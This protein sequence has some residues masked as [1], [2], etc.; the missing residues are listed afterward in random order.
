MRDGSQACG[1]RL[2]VLKPV[3]LAQLALMW[4][5][6]RRLMAPSWE[7][8]VDVDPCEAAAVSLAGECPA[9]SSSEKR[10]RRAKEDGQADDSEVPASPTRPVAELSFWHQQG[11]RPRRLVLVRHGESEANVN[12]KITSVVPDHALHLTMK[13]REQAL[14]AGRRL[15][16]IIGSSTVEFITSPYVRARETFMGIAQAWGGPKTVRV[17]DEML[18]REQDFGNFDKPIM[19]ELHQEKRHFGQ[20]YYRFPEGESPADVYTRASVFLETLYR[21]WEHSLEDNLVVVSHSMFLLV[22]MTRFFR[23]TIEDY[24]KFET[25]ENCELVVLEIKDR[26]FFQVAFTWPPGA[27]REK[28]FGGLRRRTELAPDGLAQLGCLENI[29]NGDPNE[30]EITSMPRKRPC[31]T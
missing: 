26:N 22:F 14:E 31:G 11:H 12:R 19:E 30:G 6:S 25:L 10:A 16:E 28:H 18:I 5:I 7:Q 3:D 15:R 27:E 13:G 4:R 2:T 24:Y 20:F 29:W 1:G 9:S 8:H 23:Y 21:R 17:R